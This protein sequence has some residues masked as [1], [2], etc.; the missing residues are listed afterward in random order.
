M[1]NDVTDDGTTPVGKA[2]DIARDMQKK[3]EGFQKTVQDISA[4]LPQAGK[5]MQ[6]G[7]SVPINFRVPPPQAPKW[8]VFENS[9]YNTDN[10]MKISKCGDLDEI[11]LETRDGNSYT[12]KV[13]NKE[14]LWKKLQ[15][16]FTFGANADEQQSTSTDQTSDTVQ[17]NGNGSSSTVADS[18]KG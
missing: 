4:Q 17:E 7:P 6:T 2:S 3:V 14:K 18:T 8:L 16:V 9:I 15:H 12:E 5:L 10:I 1:N 13:K 11:K